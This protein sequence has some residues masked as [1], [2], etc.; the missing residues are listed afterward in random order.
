[1]K[2]L[3]E[4]TFSFYFGRRIYKVVVHVLP[5]DSPL[6]FSHLDLDNMGLNY[7]SWYKVIERVSD[8]HAEPVEMRNNLPYLVFTCAGPRGTLEYLRLCSSLE[9]FPRYPAP[10]SMAQWLRV[11]TLSE[12]T[13]NL[14]P[15][16]AHSEYFATQ[17]DRE[18][19][20][21]W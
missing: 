20:H 16:C 19:Y 11:Q 6:I 12:N 18:T 5:G 3:G 4:V 1:M 10:G 14:L 15:G 13:R 9:Y 21:R 2:S 7:Q 8:G 17:F